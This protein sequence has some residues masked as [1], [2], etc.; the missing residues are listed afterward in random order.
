LEIISPSV[1]ERED[2]ILI[3]G[4]EVG[5]IPVKAKNYGNDVK[6]EESKKVFNW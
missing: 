2:W 3:L 4:T 6:R 5:K 1:G